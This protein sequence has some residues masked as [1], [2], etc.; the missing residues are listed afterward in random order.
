MPTDSGEFLK[1]FRAVHHPQQFDHS[2]YFVQISEGSLD[3]G[4]AVQCHIAR[5][6]VAFLDA[7]LCSKF[8]CENGLSIVIGSVS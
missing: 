2:S 5:R 1:V 3:R 8:S 4:K 6:L 7:H